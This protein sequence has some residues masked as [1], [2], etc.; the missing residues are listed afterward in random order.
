VGAKSDADSVEFDIYTCLRCETVITSTPP[1]K[2]GSGR[3]GN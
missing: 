3:S 1:K 2:T